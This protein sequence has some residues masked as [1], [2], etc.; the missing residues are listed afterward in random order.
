M[1]EGL[2]DFFYSTK[3]PKK[4]W[5]LHISSS[6]DDDWQT[7]GTVSSQATG[8]TR[9]AAPSQ[10]SPFTLAAQEGKMSEEMMNECHYAVTQFVVNLL[11]S[12]YTVS[13]LC[14]DLESSNNSCTDLLNLLFTSQK[15]HQE[16]IRQSIKNWTF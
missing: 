7:V 13:T 16:L 15:I 9:P 10:Q 8:F 4:P 6:L 2:A 3:K 11:C 12:F 5:M 1:Q 14:S